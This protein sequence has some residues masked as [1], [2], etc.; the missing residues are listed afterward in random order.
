RSLRPAASYLPFDL[1]EVSGKSPD[2]TTGMLTDIT[3]LVSQNKYKPLPFKVFPICDAVSAFRFMA[4]AKH[5]GKVVISLSGSE[6]ADCATALENTPKMIRTDAS[7]LITGGFGALGLKVA[8][9][10][11]ENG[12]RCLILVGRKG[13]SGKA[14]ETIT[15]LKNSGVQ[16]VEACADVSKID[17]MTRLMESIGDG[18]PPLKGIVHAAGGL[19]DAMLANQSGDSFEKVMAPKVW[20]AWNLHALTKDQDLDFLIFFSSAASLLG[21]PGQGNYAAANAFMDGLAHFRRRMGKPAI[22]INWGP[23]AGS[24]MAGE[25]T[26]EDEAG[27][28]F[29]GMEMI[30]PEDGLEI[31]DRLMHQQ[32]AQVGVLPI[33]WPAFLQRFSGNAIPPVF[34][35]FISE[36]NPGRPIIPPVLKALADTSSGNRLPFLS[37]HLRGRVAHVLGL[38]SV[39]MLN[40]DQPLKELGLDSLM[41]V[42][43]NNMIQSDLGVSLSAE[44][45]MENPSISQL[46]A[47]LLKVLE[48]GGALTSEGTP[49]GDEKPAPG[50]MPAKVK[51]N[52]WIAYRKAKPD[53]AVKLFCFHHMGGAASLFRTWGED[54]PDFIDVCPVQLPGREARRKETPVVRFDGLMETLSEALLPYLDRPFAFFGHSM[55]A[56]IAFELSHAVLKKHGRFPEHLFVAAMPPP[57]MNEALFN[58]AS[59]DESW[60]TYME[61]PELLKDDDGFMNEWLH[62]F[63]TDSR[64]FQSYEYGRKTRLDCPIT[65]FGGNSD[66]LAAESDLLKWRQ[67]TTKRCALEI[68]PGKH[69][70]PVESKNQLLDIITTRL[71][72]NGHD[73]TQ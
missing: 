19:A 12:A 24:G 53:A 66:E 23:W 54:V 65:V 11:A 22:S 40:A 20:G 17:E 34:R 9:R 64:L 63:K 57:S 41:A 30:D 13:A 42:E 39:D 47:S 61:I 36:R 50:G 27:T 25:L 70:F 7:Y 72:S 43:L 51:T 44:H 73:K 6:K 37:N 5:I 15:S 4:Q 31:F 49:Q 26:G 45:F 3:A 29:A 28:L 38:D 55:G 32:A 2:L 16:I 58:G 18:L 60:L 1:I 48:S 52:G 14:K 59:M 10:L 62:L 33:R 67:H 71:Q 46:S 8:K 69:M 35:H 68:L 56:W 21:S